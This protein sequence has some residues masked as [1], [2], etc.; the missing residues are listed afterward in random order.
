[1]TSYKAFLVPALLVLPIAGLGYSWI[2]TEIES[3]QG[4]EW[5]VPIA[6]YDP[7]DLLR[8]H[9]V[10]FRYDWPGLD[11]E[12]DGLVSRYNG[13]Q[14]CIHGK[15]PTIARVTKL[16]EY[17]E[18]Y[19]KQVSSCDAI[20]KY[21]PWSEEGT[22]GLNNDRLFLS[23]QKAAEYQKKLTN[24]KLQAS[25]RIRINNSNFMIPIDISFHPV[26]DEEPTGD[27]DSNEQ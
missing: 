2:T 15:A 10:Q 20:V 6:G 1:M 13:S 21:N 8:G 9:Y 27:Q 14:I 4:V 26:V 16:D 7:R 11:E 5:D 25:A 23:Q 19:E 22:D 24:Q 18:D 3:H 17:A 12:E